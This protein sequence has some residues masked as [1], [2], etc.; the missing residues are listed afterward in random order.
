MPGTEAREN[1]GH[2]TNAADHTET[3]SAAELD[4]REPMLPGDIESE[5]GEAGSEAE[6]EGELESGDE[7]SGDPAADGAPENPEAGEEDDTPMS[8]AERRRL[9]L[10]NDR[11]GNELGS[12]R[13][14]V[15]KMLE[16]ANKAKLGAP[17]A[18]EWS[19]NP[20]EAA[21]AERALS[22]E[23]QQFEAESARAER[24]TLMARMNPQYEALVPDMVK[25]LKEV[26]GL[27]E[28]A[29]EGFTKDPYSVDVGLAHNL[30]ERARLVKENALLKQRLAATNPAAK[31]PAK[32]APKF[33]TDDRA[34]RAPAKNDGGK[35]DLGRLEE[36]AASNP[37]ELDRVLQSLSPQERNA[38][39]AADQKRQRATKR[40]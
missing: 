30:A 35:L 23:Q 1:A 22:E 24:M 2:E 26:D 8:A 12:L 34:S 13:K 18:D 11:L 40:R 21:K 27:P 28:A 5:M 4:P 20:D 15:A 9:Q 36:L 3:V 33:P 32:P 39:I 7:G 25:I 29:I 37:D 14:V 16:R 17:T 19:E 10:M 6:T 38:L 31:P